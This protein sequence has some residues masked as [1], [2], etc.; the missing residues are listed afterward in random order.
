[1]VKIIGRLCEQLILREVKHQTA[2]MVEVG[3]EAML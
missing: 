3:M 1:M 2:S